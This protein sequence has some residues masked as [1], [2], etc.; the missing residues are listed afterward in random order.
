MIN[1]LIVLWGSLAVFGVLAL[2][3]ETILGE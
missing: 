1:F 3:L 2:A